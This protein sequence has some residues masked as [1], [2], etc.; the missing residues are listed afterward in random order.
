MS[1]VGKAEAVSETHAADDAWDPAESRLLP[2]YETETNG[3][4][5]GNG[6]GAPITNGG[7][8]KGTPAK[9]L[10]DSGDS[11]GEEF[12]F[13]IGSCTPGWMQCIGSKQGFLIT[14][15]ITW[16][17]QGMFNTYFVS[18]I[19]TIEK[20]FQ[21]QSRT[22]GLVL[23][24]TEIGQIS[25]SLL[26]T[27]YVGQGHRPRWI[28]WGMVLF[29][30]CSFT[31]SLPHFIFGQ[32]VLEA[33]KAVFTG[34]DLNNSST[35]IPSNI[36]LDPK[37]IN[38]DITIS[39]Q[40]NSDF[41]AEQKTQS[42]ITN[43][44]LVIF[45]FSLLGIGMGQTPVYTLGIPYIDD[46]VASRES[47]IY[48]SITIGVRILGPA[49]GFVLGSV[50]T[51]FYVDLTA[52]PKI[53]PTDPQWVGAW[54]LGLVFVSSGLI[55]FSPAMFSF[56]KRLSTYRAVAPAPPPAIK[57]KPGGESEKLGERG[58]SLRDFPKAINRLLRNDILMF[59]TASSV[60]HLLPIAGVYTFLPKYFESQFRLT[61]HDAAMVSGIGGIMV[62]GVGIILS[63]ILILRV[64]PNPRFVAAWIAAA[65]A[66]YSCG[67]F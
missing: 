54:W 19:T 60:L 1:I 24:A 43:V 34:V 49:L 64:K 37:R 65:A 2:E 36:C 45:Y 14:F 52:D 26:I 6:P 46:N 8:K 10:A 20:L 48:F 41:L 35:V 67:K 23:T 22:I 25:S 42:A 53:T 16:V 50:C 3:N 40:C 32:Q 28:A 51:R 4:I 39:S 66:I 63:G 17:L 31:T 59:R 47:P 30:I 58:P 29:A 61:A 15:C 7:L 44:V 33:N 21:V 11:H 5:V 62:M 56:P 18:V 55:L 38:D 57:A 27:Y 13:G 12:R 9:Y